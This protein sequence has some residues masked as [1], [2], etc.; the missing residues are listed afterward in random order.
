MGSINETETSIRRE[1]ERLFGEI[2]AKRG[3]LCTNPVTGGEFVYGFD[4]IKRQ[5]DAAYKRLVAR[6]HFAS[7]VPPDAPPMP[8]DEYERNRAKRRLVWLQPGDKGVRV[9][10]GKSL[11]RCTSF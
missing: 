3:D 10:R 6:E 1:V 9:R 11:Q 5:K 2:S 8:T 7:H 4:S